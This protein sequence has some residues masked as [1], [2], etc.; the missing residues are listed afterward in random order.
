M[1]RTFPRQELYDL[2]WSEPKST[3]AKRLGISDVGLAKTC[4]RADIPVPGLGYWAKLQ[5]GKKVRRLPLPPAGPGIRDA[6]TITLT[7]PLPPDVEAQ[8]QQER[9]PD[10]RITVPETL[11]DHHPLVR[12]WLDTQRRQ[13]KEA[14]RKGQQPPS[15]RLH[16]TKAER[17]RLRLLSTLLN[18]LEKRGHKVP[19]GSSDTHKVAVLVANEEVEFSLHALPPTGELVLRIEEYLDRGTRVTWRDTS[20]KR[21]EEQLNRVIVGLLTA[22]AV[23]RERRLKWEEA[24]RREKAAKEE[25]MRQEEAR[26][27]EEERRAHLLRSLQAWRQAADI[28]TYVDA[29]RAAAATG[30][31]KI[32]PTH[33]EQWA[34]WALARADQIDPLLSDN[35]LPG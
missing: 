31:F 19:T 14:I 27:Q 22:A 16:F 4:R 28:R 23:L 6:V 7:P 1:T 34:S 5:H 33:L 3:L 13:L 10:R 26:R 15:S 30:Q 18:E 32:D 2:V 21:L 9:S 35:P 8:I 24:A 11:T 29:L 17:R 20:I 25:R 12:A